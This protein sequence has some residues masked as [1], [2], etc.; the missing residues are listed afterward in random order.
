MK[1]LD[2]KTGDM[3]S[4]NPQVAAMINLLGED[5]YEVR[6]VSDKF[7]YLDEAPYFPVPIEDVESILEDVEV[8][9]DNALPET[10]SRNTFAMF[11]SP[12]EWLAEVVNA[13]LDDVEEERAAKSTSVYRK[14][15]LKK[16][17]NVYSSVLDKLEEVED[18]ISTYGNT[19]SH[20]EIIANGLV[21]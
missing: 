21:Q 15:E 13:R 17:E 11:S 7:V 8:L 1:T 19:F 5:Y 6:A 2:V 16:I 18:A 3:V 4:I 14:G 20:E 12:A 9:D 10:E